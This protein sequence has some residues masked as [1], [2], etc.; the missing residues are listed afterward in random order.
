MQQATLEGFRLSPQQS[1]LWRLQPN[2]A[3]SPYRA[4]CTVCIDGVLDRARLQAALAQLV[5]RYELLRT[6]FQRLPAMDLP[7]QVIGPAWQPTVAMV[8]GNDSRHDDT[9]A[10]DG[11]RPLAIAL[12]QLA[13]DQHRLHLALPALYA[14]AVGL[15]NL[16]HELSVCY[17]SLLDDTE[18]PGNTLSPADEEILQYVD[19]AEWQHELL[20]SEETAEGRAYWRQHA[21][22]D[23]LAVRLPFTQW[24]ST[25][26]TA[27]THVQNGAVS[28]KGAMAALHSNGTHPTGDTAH[29]T[30]QHEAVAPDDFQP[31]FYTITLP[32]ARVGQMVALATHQETT[33]ATLLLASWQILLW[34]LTA[35]EDVLVGV[36]YDGR[37]FEELRD[38]LGLFARHLPVRT[39]LDNTLPLAQLMAQLHEQTSELGK[40]QEYFA[41][42]HC[43]DISD[44][45]AATYVPFCFAYD[46]PLGNYVGGNVTFTVEQRSSCCDRYHIKLHCRP[47]GDTLTVKFHYDANLMAHDEIVRLAD[48]FVTLVENAIQTPDAAVATLAHVMNNFDRARGIS[49]DYPQA[50]GGHLE[51]AGL[52]AEKGSAYATEFTS[53]TSLTDMD[54]L[55]F[56]I[57]DYSGL[58]YSRLDL[59]ALK[60]LTEPRALPLATLSNAAADATGRLMAASA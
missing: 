10:Q 5:A 37:K 1:H 14:D 53:W 24:Q 49:I 57:R 58:N 4:Y 22:T 18:S 8:D 12:E 59:S 50:G 41:W 6:S 15:E 38:A 16:V 47:A 23:L 42:E 26:L 48:Q 35:R 25:R 17:G 43:G 36:T 46:R 31:Q 19:L 2:V 21:V 32:A 29:V 11:E 39:T 55:I 28:T 45:E 33:L 34:R 7:L 40:W 27:L 52:E 44:G 54:R 9:N 13:T 30:E 51:V 3:A 60:A 56:F 20:E